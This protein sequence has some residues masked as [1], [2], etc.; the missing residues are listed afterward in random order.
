MPIRTYTLPEME[1]KGGSEPTP[2]PFKLA[3]M[4]GPEL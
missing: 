4:T 2:V 3:K 1:T